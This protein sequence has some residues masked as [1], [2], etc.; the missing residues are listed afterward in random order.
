ME[1]LIIFGYREIDAFLEGDEEMEDLS[2]EDDFHSFLNG[3]D[4]NDSNDEENDSN[5]E[6]N[7]SNIEDNDSHHEKNDS[8]DEENDSNDEENVSNDEAN[9]FNE[10]YYSDEEYDSY[11]GENDS[12]DSNDE[13]NDSNAEDIESMGLFNDHNEDPTEYCW[14]DLSTINC[15]FPK[16]KML[17]LPGCTET[18]IVESLAPKCPSY[19]KII[20]DRKLVGEAVKAR[21]TK[22]YSYSTY[23]RMIH[24]SLL[25]LFKF[26]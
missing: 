4:D 9:D 20:T 13:Q 1:Y 7:D 11:N 3:I 18:S 15:R 23:W 8:E 14:P 17:L 25:E 22:D 10:Y 16:L 2:D 21:I 5:D 12:I 6:D 19:V 26:D 24:P